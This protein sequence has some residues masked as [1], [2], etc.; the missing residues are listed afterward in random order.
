MSRNDLIE[1]T[2]KKQIENCEVGDNC[3]GEGRF[4][5]RYFPCADE[6]DSMDE[7]LK[8]KPV[9]MCKHHLKRYMEDEDNKYT[10]YH[11]ILVE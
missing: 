4:G 5:I 10:E 8:T 2:I 1:L 9:V 11:H 3:M 7:V 6:S